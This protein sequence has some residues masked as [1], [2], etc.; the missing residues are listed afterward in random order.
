MTPGLDSDLGASGVSALNELSST[1]AHAGAMP[2]LEIPASS[3]LTFSPTSS[4]T[5]GRELNQAK[6]SREFSHQSTLHASSSTSTLCSPSVTNNAGPKQHL[7]MANPEDA[8]VNSS[9]EAVYAQVEVLSQARGQL[10]ASRS[11]V[12]DQQEE[13]LGKQKLKRHQDQMLQWSQSLHHEVDILV[14][15]KL[16]LQGLLSSAQADDLQSTIM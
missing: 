1:P 14:Q 3:L 12:G 10:D 5:H 2:Q 8:I 13:S 4:F 11:K 9:R 6:G 16:Q 7:M 15:D